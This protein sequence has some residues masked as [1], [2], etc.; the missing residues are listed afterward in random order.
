MDDAGNFFITPNDWIQ[1]VLAG[2]FGQRP[3]I[4]NK[5]LIFLNAFVISESALFDFLDQKQN[6]FFFNFETRKHVPS[7]TFYI[8]AGDK[9]M[10][11]G[12]KFVTHATG[13]L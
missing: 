5:G 13:H 8:K 12:N 9:K 7:L 1:F 2:K 10:L 4:F 11:G 3:G 6:F